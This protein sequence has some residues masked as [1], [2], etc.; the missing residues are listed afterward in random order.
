M[1]ERIG[2][3]EYEKEEMIDR[4]C[5]EKGKNVEEE[6]A[7]LSLEVST[8]VSNGSIVVNTIT[9]KD[10]GGSEGLVGKKEKGGCCG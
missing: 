4:I 6:F 8:R 5:S 1:K 2:W 9:G 3:S 10:G 7:R